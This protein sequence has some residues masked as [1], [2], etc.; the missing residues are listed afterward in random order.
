MSGVEI[1]SLLRE[2]VDGSVTVG[3]DYARPG[4]MRVLRFEIVV[5]A[6]GEEVLARELRRVERLAG[7]EAEVFESGPWRP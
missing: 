7:R 3:P 1:R 6:D 5:P 4:E 2:N